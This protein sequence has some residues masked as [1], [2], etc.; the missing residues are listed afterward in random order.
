MVFR[1]DHRLDLTSKRF[2]VAASLMNL[3]RRIASFVDALAHAKSLI[4]LD[5]HSA[6]GAN[7]RACEAYA[8]IDYQTHEDEEASVVC[9][10][11]I[12]TTA[13]ILRKAQAVNKAKEEFKA[14]CAPLHR[15]QVR[16][17]VKGENSPTR[18]V[19]AMRVILRNIQR[20]DLNL[21]AGYRKIPI[22][23][24]PPATVTYTRA[25]TRSVYR[26]SIDEVADLLQNLNSPA[27]I[28]DRERLESLDRRVTHLALV[29]ERYQ[30]IRANVLYARL[31]AKGRGRIQIAAELPLIY[32]TGRRVSAPDVHFPHTDTSP[33]PKRVRES[34]LEGLP[35]LASLPIHRYRA[36]D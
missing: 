19:S 28:A 35:F 29:K 16:I 6:A 30:N 20:S 33:N 9:L 1:G 10:G 32:A 21:L 4:T 18:A 12:G 25:N 31:D 23:G 13:D 17:P 36:V 26:K 11:V 24:A 5:G 34:K 8:A 3:E 15:V 2:E 22:L 14:L 27:A 7:R